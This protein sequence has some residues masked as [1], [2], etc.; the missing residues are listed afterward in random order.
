MMAM[1]SPMMA[2]CNTTDGYYF[3]NDDYDNT[4]DDY[5]FT[6]DGLFNTYDSYCHSTDGLINSNRLKPL[7]KSWND[8]QK[9]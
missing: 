1:T 6:N 3:T 2:F 8:F 5:Y 4:N 7:L 9:V